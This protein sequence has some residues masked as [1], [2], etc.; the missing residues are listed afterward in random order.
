MLGDHKFS[1][2]QKA[3]FKDSQFFMIVVDVTNK[4][5]FENIHKFIEPIRLNCSIEFK[6]Y[7]LANKIDSENRIVTD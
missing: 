6:I 4:D 3:H 5:S 2:P 1:A 7:I